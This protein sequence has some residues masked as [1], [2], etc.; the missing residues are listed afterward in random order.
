M[1]HSTIENVNIKSVVLLATPKK[2]REILPHTPKTIRAVRE[3]RQTISRILDGRDNRLLAIVGPCSINNLEAAEAYAVRLAKLAEKVSDT[4]CVVMRVY[5]E[6]PRSV[7]GWKGLINDPYLDDTFKME[8]GLKMARRFLLRIAE[9]GLPAA[10]EVLDT[11]T[12]QY[13]GDLISWSAI[14]ART[15]ESQTHREI[16]SGISTPVGFKN[17]TDGSLEAAIN[18]IKS[19]SGE[20][21]FLGATYDGLPAV[22]STSGNPYS[23]IVLRGGKRPNYDAESISECE[24]ALEDAGIRPK[25]VVDCSHGNSRKKPERQGLVLRD[26]LTQKENGNTSICGFMLESFLEWGCQPIPDDV[27]KLRPGLSITDACIDWKT[28]EELLLEAHKRLT[29]LKGQKPRTKTAK[30][31]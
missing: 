8:D 22:F 1:N 27:K 21:H 18:G 28:T 25:I 29:A 26:L 16:A 10:S 13:L 2:L 31:K 7:L 9:I 5:F 20:H 24:K 4:L 6:K 19:A 30:R 11:L 12:P 3:G 17:A 14:G 15:S 23:H